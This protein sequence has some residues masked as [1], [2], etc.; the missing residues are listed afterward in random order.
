MH[1]QVS[2]APPRLWWCPTGPFSFLPIHAAGI[3]DGER[4]V[5]LS[6]YVTS[7]YI[8]TLD[9][10]P[11][12]PPLSEGFSM[13]AVIEAETPGQSKL[14]CALKELEMIQKHISDTQLAIM[15]TK[16]SPSSVKGISSCLNSAS[17]VH[18]ACHGYQ[19]PVNPLRSALFIRDGHIT[20][21]KIMESP[22][23]KARLAFLN[24][25]E[26]AK[27]DDCTPD[28]VMHLSASLLFAGFHGVIGTMWYIHFAFT[29][30]VCLHNI[31]PS[32][33]KM[34]H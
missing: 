4:Q 15:G 10:L 3:Y 14:P 27:G 16:E 30:L 23:P 1:S 32:M 5:C 34:L 22:L 9:T 26:T 29:G 18:F 20:I 8:P 28:E 2:D 17:L 31:G 33:M 21:A 19:D 12:P 13:L 6:N 25:C 11:V 24:A 7:S